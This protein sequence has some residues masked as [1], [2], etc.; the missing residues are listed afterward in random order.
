V[1][2]FWGWRSIAT[3]VAPGDRGR[4]PDPADE[5]AWIGQEREHRLGRS[6]DAPLPAGG[7]LLC[8]GLQPL[9]APRP[10]LLEKGPQLAESLL[11]QPVEP[12]RAVRPHRHE[13]RLLEHAQVLRDRRRRE[14]EVR[15]DLTGRQL[16][17]FDEE[18]ED[19]PPVG[20]GDGLK[21]GSH[22]PILSNGLTKHN[23]RMDVARLPG[24][25]GICARAVLPRRRRPRTNRRGNSSARIRSRHPRRPGRGG[26]ACR[27]SR[28]PSRRAGRRGP[29]AA[30]SAPVAGRRR[31]ARG[32]RGGR[33]ALR[34]SGGD[35]P[36]AEP[37]AERGESLVRR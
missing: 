28:L 19:A 34:A 3:V 33:C 15:R 23:R 20:L 9:E 26:A 21:G 10:E 22:A 4:D 36:P 37:R 11:A 7:F 13:P 8:R 16:V 1:P 6:G 27:C 30:A 2:P 5:A 25:R 35:A 32:R 14:A 18:L 31:K 24:L 17:R 29:Q 12:P